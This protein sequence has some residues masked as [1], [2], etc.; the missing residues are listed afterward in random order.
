MPPEKI[1]F[2]KR[3]FISSCNR[4]YRDGNE[5]T[6]KQWL[7]FWEDHPLYDE[8]VAVANSVVL[9]R[10]NENQ[11]WS[12]GN[13]RAIRRADRL[14]ELKKAGTLKRIGRKPGEANVTYKDL[15][16]LTVKQWLEEVRAK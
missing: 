4:F 12:I 1:K 2:L 14:I 15:R 9:A 3:Y 11:P 10:I 5:L 16:V 13:L 8:K 7:E 6:L